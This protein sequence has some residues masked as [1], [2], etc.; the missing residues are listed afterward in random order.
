MTQFLTGVVLTLIVLTVFLL[1]PR[2]NPSSPSSTSY[3]SYT[4][5]GIEQFTATTTKKGTKKASTKGTTTVVKTTTVKPS[6]KKPTTVITTTTTTTSKPPT[7]LLTTAAPTMMMTAPP[8]QGTCPGGAP[9]E[10]CAKILR[11]PI[12]PT[13]CAAVSFKNGDRSFDRT[14][15]FPPSDLRTCNAATAR[16][17]LILRFRGRRLLLP[18]LKCVAARLLKV[19]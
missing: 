12:V 1:Y 18:S 5:Y 4:P 15:T 11:A 3:V 7:T 9:P 16:L 2:M 17:R 13:R 19:F 10:S 6:T 8:A 14:L